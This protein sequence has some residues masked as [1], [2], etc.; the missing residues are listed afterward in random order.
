[1]ELR[2]DTAA[3][4]ALELSALD[5]SNRALQTQIWALE[6]E[7]RAASEAAA[8]AERLRTAWTQIT[9]SL[10]S[11]VK[12]IRGVM[13]GGSSPIPA[14]QSAPSLLELVTKR[15]PMP[16]DAA[17]ARFVTSSREGSYAPGPRSAVPGAS[18]GAK[19]EGAG[20]FVRLESGAVWPIIP[21]TF[22]REEAFS[23]AMSLARP[24]MVG[25]KQVGTGWND[26]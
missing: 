16:K 19:V 14:T 7:A 18:A 6:D 10:I 17:G 24:M 9:D 25:V 5:A 21:S 15:A 26:A 8:A 20:V 13:G 4:R 2:G 22:M 11:E 23:I 3:L 1:M 12:R